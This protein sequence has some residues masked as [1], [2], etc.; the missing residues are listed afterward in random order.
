MWVMWFAHLSLL[1][2]QSAQEL[3]ERRWWSLTQAVTE[4]LLR[5]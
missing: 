4:A 2:A 3:D 5:A 1:H